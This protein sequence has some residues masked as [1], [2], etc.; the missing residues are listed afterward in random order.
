MSRPPHPPWFIHPNNVRWIMQAKKFIIMQCFPES[1]I[2][3]FRSKIL[4]SAL[5]SKSLSLCS[6]RKERD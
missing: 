6:S 3:P 1:F 5:F 4:L 2:L